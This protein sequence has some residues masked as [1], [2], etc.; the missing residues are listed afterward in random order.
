MV[1]RADG[2]VYSNRAQRSWVGMGNSRFMSTTLQPGD[3]I[4]VPE[5]ADKR[6]GYTRFIEG[7]KDWTQLLYQ[8]GIG[9][10]AWKQ[11]N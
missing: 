3:A 2:S 11:L 1:V 6:T 4:F 7:A 8:F 5:E 10:A 9:A